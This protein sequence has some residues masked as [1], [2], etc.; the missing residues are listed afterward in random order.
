MPLLP[1]IRRGPRGPK[2]PS[3]VPEREPRIERILGAE[4]VAGTPGLRWLNIEQ[5]SSVEMAVL[6]DEFTFHELDFEDVLSRRQ[7]PKVDEYADYLFVVLHF[8]RYDKAAGRLGTAELD[9]F[10]G[11]DFL[12]TC[13]NQP[14]RP[15]GR[16]FHRCQN[17][18]DYRNELFAKGP[19]YV[20]YVVLSDLFDY[21]F[22]ILDK[23]GHKLDEIED[24]LFEGR[25]KDMVRQISNTKQEIIAYR[26]I[27]SPELSTLRVLEAKTAT[28]F[29]PGTLEVYYDDVI[30]AGQR[31]W[32]LLENYKEVVEALED[33]SETVVQHDLND[34]LLLL[35]VLNALVLP[36]TFITGLFG[37]N[38]AI[39]FQHYN[40]AFW[41]IV[42]M[43]V[44]V[45]G[46]FVVWFK[47]SKRF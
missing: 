17:D 8:P 40:H 28:R 4:T 13:P 20:L 38:V 10:I 16:V 44:G 7:R 32:D 45:V 31:I 41:L 22:P 46:A 29:L 12:I 27:I 43:I 5:P 33:T 37:M 35:T 6:A 26:K 24:A 36:M 21:C 39:P 2:L 23:V 11:P 1:R 3:A 19:G 14:L 15:L 47:Q 25:A 18:V 30:D 9:I 34:T 42:A